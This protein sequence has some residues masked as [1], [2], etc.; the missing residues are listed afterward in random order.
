MTEL[1]GSDIAGG[2]LRPSN[3]A[4]IGCGWRA[5]GTAGI[6]G[7]AAIQEGMGRRWTAIILE[8]TEQ[9]G[10]IDEVTR[11]GKTAG[12]IAVQVMA[13]RNNRGC[14]G[15]AVSNKSSTKI[16]R[17]DSVLELCRGRKRASKRDK[18]S[19]TTPTRIATDGDVG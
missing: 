3:A 7:R 2:T 9:R 19:T 12:V 5:I 4:L 14:R 6:N 17:Y 1:V 15:A 10:G 16:V 8:W 13:E 18:D 11:T